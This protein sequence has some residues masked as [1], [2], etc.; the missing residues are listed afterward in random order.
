MLMNTAVQIEWGNDPD[1][2]ITAHEEMLSCHSS[3]FARI[4]TEAKALRKKYALC[5]E[6]LDQAALL[7][8]PEMSLSGFEE[9]GLR[10]RVC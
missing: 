1:L 9:A 10:E 4:C 8:Y 3:R 7:V 2:S 6:L 5:R